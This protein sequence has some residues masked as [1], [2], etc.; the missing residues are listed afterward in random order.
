[1]YWFWERH[2]WIETGVQSITRKYICKNGARH[3]K[4]LEYLGTVVTSQNHFTVRQD[5]YA[6]AE[7]E[8][9]Q[10]TSVM[11]KKY[12]KPSPLRLNGNN[13]SYFQ[14]R[15]PSLWKIPKTSSFSLL[16][17]SCLNWRLLCRPWSIQHTVQDIV[18]Q[19]TLCWSNDSNSCN[20][21]KACWSRV[22]KM[23]NETKF[24]V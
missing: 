14:W 18:R 7:R 11:T 1:M 23:L 13:S 21:L 2:S 6:V 16:H 3:A 12:R 15:V 24:M 19:R 5:E 22:Q 20:F 4:H 17:L 10:R 9:T 8:T